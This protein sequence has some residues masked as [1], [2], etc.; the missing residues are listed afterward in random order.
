MVSWIWIP[1]SVMVGCM[2]GIMLIGL[3]AANNYKE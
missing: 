3:V 1:V 2:I